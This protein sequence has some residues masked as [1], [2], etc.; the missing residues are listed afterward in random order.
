MFLS[1]NLR[2]S[3][4]SLT[5]NCGNPGSPSGGYTSGSSYTYGSQVTF[6]CN[7]GLTLRGSASATCMADSTWSNPTPKCKLWVCFRLF[8]QWFYAISSNCLWL[9]FKLHVLVQ[10]WDFQLIGLAFNIRHKLAELW[11]GGWVYIAFQSF[12]QVCYTLNSIYI[13]I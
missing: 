2:T 8:Y 12:I 13:W 3:L 11:R 5:A 4:R 7:S 6:H 9:T 10:R 1:Q